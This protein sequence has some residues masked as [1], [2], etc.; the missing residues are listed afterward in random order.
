[1]DRDHH[2][3][4]AQL[5]VVGRQPVV[6]GARGVRRGEHAGVDPG[7]LRAQRRKGHQD[8]GSGG[9]GG[10]RPGPPQDRGGEPRPTRLG[11]IRHAAARHQPRAHPREQRGQD[12]QRDRRRDQGDH[13][14][15]DADRLEELLGEDDQ[16]EHGRGHGERT[17]HDGATGGRHRDA[18]RIVLAA[19]RAQLLAEARHE[20]Q[21]VVDG[22]TQAEAEDH[23]QR[24]DRQAVDAIDE[25][26]DQER[27]H[28]AQEPDHQR[29]R[30][31][32]PSAEE[33]EGQH[34]QEREGEHLGTAQIAV[35]LIADLLSGH[36]GA[37]ERHARHVLEAMR[38]AGDDVALVGRGRERRGDQRRAP[39]RG[40]ERAPAG[41]SAGVRTTATPGTP[42]ST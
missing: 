6:D 41:W 26:D 12:E 1:V 25:P 37:A 35:D 42:C 5:R 39:V 34:H 2:G 8:H 38:R 13:G 17:E 20:E 15:A 10:D 29:Q 28:D 36:R 33:E 27:A 9:D 11:R 16:R 31:G 22:Q 32:A 30:R 3:I 7:P 4:G 19:P 24:V 14:A 40:D 21:G 18:D 23:V